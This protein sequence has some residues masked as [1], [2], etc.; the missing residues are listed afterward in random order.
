[1]ANIKAISFDTH[2]IFSKL[3][4]DPYI[5]FDELLKIDDLVSIRTKNTTELPIVILSHYDDILNFLKL[6][7]EVSCNSKYFHEELPKSFLDYFLL[8]NDGVAHLA[9][10]KIFSNFFSKSRLISMEAQITDKIMKVVENLN[11]CDE[12]DLI[13]QIAEPIPLYVLGMMLNSSSLDNLYK[14]RRWALDVGPDYDTLDIKALHSSSPIHESTRVI[15]DFCS[16]L[17]NER[18]KELSDDI[19]S[20]MIIE[21]KKLKTNEE[22]M[23]ANLI[24]FLFVAHDSTVNMIGNGLWLLLTHPEQLN[25]LILEPNL[26]ELSVNEILRYESPL[27]RASY[28]VTKNDIKIREHIIPA[29]TQIILFLGAAN[30]DPKIFDNPNIFN[31]YRKN[32]PHLAFGYGLHNCVG[33]SLALMEGRLLFPKIANYLNQVKVVNDGPYWKKLTHFR[34]LEK[35]MVSKI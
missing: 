26:A 11:G 32:N 9:L 4:S 5:L 1:M 7:N 21:C 22:V 10:R 25:A 8:N 14:I 18:K 31:I 34:G 17:I 29:K 35:L 30:R 24:S 2:E 3:I 16:D 6:N 13:E 15:F 27:K 12:A 19:V 23:L 20:H 28:R 33:K